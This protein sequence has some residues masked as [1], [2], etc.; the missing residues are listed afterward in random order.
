MTKFAVTWLIFVVVLD[1]FFFMGQLAVNDINPTSGTQ[2]FDT[3]GSI[4][5]QNDMGNYTLNEDVLG[6]LPAGE[7]S[8]SPETG[9]IFTDIFS[10][11]KAWIADTTGLNYIVAYINAFPNFLKILNLPAAFVFVVGSAWH[12]INVFALILLLWGRD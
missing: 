1:A 10:S 12:T 5:A 11:M 4:A 7:G 6:K 8:V 2:F 9:N 3:S